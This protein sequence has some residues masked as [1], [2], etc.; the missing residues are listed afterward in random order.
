MASRSY[1]SFPILDSLWSSSQ[2]PLCL[3][4]FS[5]TPVCH[6]GLP[7]LWSFFIVAT[8]R[9]L[10]FILQL[11]STPSWT[12]NLLC[13]SSRIP[14]A[15][16]QTSLQFFFCNFFLERFFFFEVDCFL[17]SS[18]NLLRSIASVV[19]FGLW[20]QS[21]WSQPPTSS[22]TCTPAL[23]GKSQPPDHQGRPF[24]LQF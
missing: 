7:S 8:F 10:T 11:I 17:K 4:A 5:W 22:W 15:G 9:W 21:V 6:G 2:F 16:S 18:L 14:A 24:L 12:E 13:A 23:E 20:P 3:R 19:C 1:H